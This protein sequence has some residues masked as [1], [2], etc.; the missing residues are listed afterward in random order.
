MSIQIIQDRLNGQLWET[1]LA[2]QQALREIIQEIILAA[3]GRGDFF[4]HAVFQGGTCLRIFH[5]LDRFS[6]DLDFILREPNPEF[7]WSDYAIQIKREVEAYGLNFTTK[8]KSEMNAAVKKVFIKEDSLGKVLALQYAPR[9]GPAKQIRIKLE[10]DTNPPSGSGC[11]IKYLSFPFQASVAVQDLPSLFAGKIHALLC[12]TY[13]KGR[14]WYDFLWYTSRGTAVN[15]R[16][17]ESALNQCGPWAD[18]R[19]AIDIDWVVEHLGLRIRTLNMRE[20]A[21]D[22]LNFVSENEH[23]SLNAWTVDYFLDRLEQWA[24]RQ[25]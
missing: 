10:V 22:V 12:R 21:G 24:Q 18:N 16:F 9:T 25:A 4:K 8:D 1:Q 5:G 7:E 19:Q 6:E 11:E 14:D 15:C 20:V 17:L 3:L 13:I 2:E 23:A